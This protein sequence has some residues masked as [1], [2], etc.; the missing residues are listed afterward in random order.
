[1]ATSTEQNVLSKPKHTP[2]VY[3]DLLRN[4]HVVLMDA[5]NQTQDG[6]LKNKWSKM[7]FVLIV[8]SVEVLTE[9]NGQ[10]PM[11]SEIGP[12]IKIKSWPR[13][14]DRL[15]EEGILISYESYNEDTQRAC[16][17]L[18]VSTQGRRELYETLRR[19]DAYLGKWIA[20]TKDA[21]PSGVEQVE[22]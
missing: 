7:R 18:A 14:I 5:Y 10:N 9:R 22:G 11:K 12:H 1:M 13:P 3:H 17:R 21:I 16:K 4:I 2:E 6:P 15:V 20:W 19:F 8:L